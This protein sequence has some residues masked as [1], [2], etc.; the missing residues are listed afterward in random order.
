LEPRLAFGGEW[1]AF[2]FYFFF[3]F[4]FDPVFFLFDIHV[5]FD[6]QCVY[7]DWISIY[8]HILGYGRG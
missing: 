5:D 4:L 3:F 1:M 2:Y 7:T 8:R 6:V